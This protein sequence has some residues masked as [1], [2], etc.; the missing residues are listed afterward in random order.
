MCLNKKIWHGIFSHNAYS[1]VAQK[2]TDNETF[3][4]WAGLHMI[5]KYKISNLSYE[6]IK[7]SQNN[8]FCLVLFTIDKEKFINNDGLNPTDCKNY[9]VYSFDTEEEL[10][11]I[12]SQL[13]I[14]PSQFT[15][16]WNC[17]YPFN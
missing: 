12:C 11:N 7:L 4:S 1:V 14:D 15:Q 16:R 8:N 6:F 17:D 9:I 2:L 5:N 3:I 10:Y 13:N